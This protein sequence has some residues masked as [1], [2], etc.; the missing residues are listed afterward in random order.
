MSEKVQIWSTKH[1]TI[2][3]ITSFL[4]NQKELDENPIAKEMFEKKIWHK[5]YD[6]AFQKAT[7]QI[8]EVIAQHRKITTKLMNIDLSDKTPKNANLN[9]FKVW[10]FDYFDDGVVEMD[11]YQEPSQETVV[12]SVYGQRAFEK[13]I[14]YFDTK[15]EA[16][17]KAEQDRLDYIADLESDI[18]SNQKDLAEY[19]SMKFTV[20]CLDGKPPVISEP[21]SSPS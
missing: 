11:V 12:Y 1:A 7:S 2:Q 8:A 15:E 19:K 10:V 21:Q 3:G 9:T 13:G 6:E 4:M 14:R 5:T 17:A 18:A 16:V 20:D